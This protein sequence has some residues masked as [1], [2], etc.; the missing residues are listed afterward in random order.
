VASSAEKA[1]ARA[2]SSLETGQLDEA[3]RSFKKVLEAQPKHF[4][5]LNLLAVVLIQRGRL[6]EAERYLRRALSENSKSDS[7]HCNYGMVLAALNRPVE[8]VEQFTKAL[9]INPTAETLNSRGTVFNQL[10]RYSEAIADFDKAISLNPRYPDAYC[11]KGASLAELKLWDQSLSAHGTALSLRPTYAQAWV[12]VGRALSGLGRDDE[13]LSAFDKALANTPGMASAWFGRATVFFNRKHYGEAL[14]ACDKALALDPDFLRAWTGRGDVLC[15]LNRYDEALVAFDKALVLESRFSI[16]WLGQANAL[17]GLKN[18]QDALVAYDKALALEP[19]LIAAW[20]GRGNCCFELKRKEEAREAHEQALKLDPTSVAALI[21]LGSVHSDMRHDELALANFYKATAIAPY[22]KAA[23]IGLGKVYY[24]ANRNAEALHSF[25]RALELDPDYPEAHYN[26]SLVKLALGEYEEGWRLFEWRRKVRFDRS[27]AQDSAC[28]PWLGETD[29]SGKTVLAF[30]E[31]GL[32]D[33]IQFYRYLKNFESLGCDVIFE[34]P[35]PLVPLIV[36]QNQPFRVVARGDETPEFDVLF[37]L[38]SAPLAFKTTLDTIPASV[39]Y[40]AAPSERTSLWRSRLG[41][42]RKARIGL[43]WA[44]SPGSVNDVQRSMPLKFLLPIISENAEWFSLQKDV[45]D[46]DREALSATPAII[47]HAEAFADFN[48]T[49][50][51]ITELD[52]VIA[53]DS[54]ISHLAGA[55]G[56]PVWI[57]LAHHAD[58]RYLR[59][60]DDNPWYPTARLFRQRTEGDWT[61]VI[62]LLQPKLGEFLRLS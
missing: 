13:A 54:V 52:L 58:H 30:A 47:N 8:A 42:K 40:L 21:G 9:A 17:Y 10:G 51:L 22:D 49:A 1:W 7:T 16:A 35:P 37:P 3:E 60:R 56:K 2:L 31:Q 23:W 32:G 43:A 38:M 28:D 33:T 45:R 62:D 24:E 34:A 53:V 59:D 20:V 18:Y 36:Q 6:E 14:D 4:G 29:I 15:E 50:A 27:I 41:A 44:G 46:G 61:S 11:N 26:K 25:E 48:D 57:L 39:P 12:G 55:L 5:G 19:T